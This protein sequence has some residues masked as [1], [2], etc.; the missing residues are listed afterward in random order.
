M[1]REPHLASP[2]DWT[3]DA[4]LEAVKAALAAREQHTDEGGAIE[5]VQTHIS[6]VFL[7]ARY[8]FKF[9]R[10]VD[11]GFVDFRTLRRRRHFCREEVRLNRR[12]APDV[13][14]DVVGLYRDGDDRGSFSLE[15]GTGELVDYAVVMQRLPRE[16]MLDEELAAGKVTPA[17]MERLADFLARFHRR[18]HATPSHAHFGD[19]ENWHRN[20]DENWRQTEPFVGQ[21]LSRARFDDLRAQVE[22][23]MHEQQPSFQARIARETV[24]NGHGDLRCEHV[25]LGE[26]IQVID[27]VEFN[28]RFRYGDVANDLAF[29]LM[30]LCAL[31]HPAL[32]R[33]LLFAYRDA[34]GDGEMLALMPFYLC[35]RAF[36]R[37]KVTAMMLDGGSDPLRQATLRQ[38]ATRFFELA[39]IFS[40]QFGPPVVLIVSGLMGSGKSFLSRHLAEHT[41]AHLLQSDAIRKDLAALSQ[42]PPGDE[43]AAQAS[44]GSGIYTS[45]WNERTYTEVFHQAGEHLATHASVILDCSFSRRDYRERAFQLARERGAEAWLLHCVVPDEVAR[46]RLQKRA[47]SDDVLSDGRTHLFPSQKASFEP[48]VE[49]PADR[50]L[51]L[52][53]DQS[54]EQLMALVFDYPGLRVPAPLL[55]LAS[56]G[57]GP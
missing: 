12:L 54:P 7:T 24:R 56:E 27:C 3:D 41:G 32:A 37:G 43:S 13:Y 38:R 40:R 10:P 46:D 51:T 35:Y 34:M 45:E 42:T 2:P 9:K 48:P 47:Q 22:G 30:D 33:H 11:L 50:C 39:S 25:R 1:T 6:A 29:L 44:Y 20:W 53:C 28:E 26:S 57:A 14:L 31:G 23:F 19:L 21:V 18:V 5:V 36:V 16:E 17:D 55:S 52:H 4:H 8:V 15:P 49:V